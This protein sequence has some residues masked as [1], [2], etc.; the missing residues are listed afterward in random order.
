[1]KAVYFNE[2]GSIDV[3][4][5]GELPDPVPASNEVLVKVKACGVNHIDL[6]GRQGLQFIKMP[7]PFVLGTDVSGEVVAAGSSA[8]SSLIG[9]KVVINPGVSCNR[10]ERCLSG[11]D[12][13]CPDYVLMGEHFHGGNAQ[14]L[15]IP[16]ENLVPLPDGISWENAAAVPVVFVTAWNMLF[17]TGGLQ[18]GE[19]VLIQ[20]AG[21][22]VSSAA[23]QLARLA[24]ARIITTASS[25]EKLEKAR[26]LGAHHV[27]N[28]QKQDFAR[29][30]RRIT[31]KLGVDMVLDHIGESLWERNLACL[32][33]GGRLVTCGATS[34]YEAKTDLRRVF[35]LQLQILG[36]TSASKSVLFKIMKLLQDGEIRPVVDRVL[37]LAE[38][39]QA[40][41]ILEERK[42]FGKIVLI[43]E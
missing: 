5:Y 24:G 8:H 29:E 41:R 28:Y 4:R 25:E 6:W 33:K 22:G 10:C 11:M 39:A 35:F 21:S 20:A 2:H 13:Q 42:Q 36:A 3:L 43:P 23:I 34:G 9:K 15:K 31:N 7:F 18:P 30:V 1:M 16:V 17:D 38:A 32:R 19:W 14:L 40:H 12:H 26:A 37:P 27:I